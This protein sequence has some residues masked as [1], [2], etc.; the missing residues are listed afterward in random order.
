MQEASRKPETKRGSA[1]SWKYWTQTLFSAPGRGV[2]TLRSRLTWNGVSYGSDKN[3]YRDISE[4]SFSGWRTELQKVQV[5]SQAVLKVKPTPTLVTLKWSPPGK[6]AGAPGSAW[7]APTEKEVG[8]GTCELPMLQAESVKKARM[9][10]YS[11]MGVVG[12]RAFLGKSPDRGAA[13]P[14]NEGGESST[15]GRWQR[16]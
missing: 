11:L 8:A 1:T 9:S 12:V 5:E 14:R 6:L 10:L 7:H 2:Q 16:R 3:P 15:S 13:L 4:R